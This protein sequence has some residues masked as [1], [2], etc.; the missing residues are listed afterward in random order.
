[1]RRTLLFACS[2]LLI[3]ALAAAQHSSGASSSEAHHSA[4]A[5]TASVNSS[6]A[7]SSSHAESASHLV[8]ENR[9]PAGSHTTGTS[10]SVGSRS[11]SAAGT[12]HGSANPK[13]PK[14]PLSGLPPA[15]F[16]HPTLTPTASSSQPNY[17]YPQSGGSALGGGYLFFSPALY[18]ESD[19]TGAAGGATDETLAND[20]EDAVAGNDA[21][22]NAPECRPP[23]GS[24]SETAEAAGQAP[25][26]AVPEPEA[27]QYVFVRRDGGLLFAIGYSWDRDTLRYITGDGT[28]KAV[29]RDSLDLDATKKFNQQLGL[30]FSIPA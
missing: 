30:I 4:A 22:T 16:H 25:E 2:I 8:A 9:T 12:S 15:A 13:G 11:T 20:S 5:H 1:M 18:F 17:V 23:L 14:S 19:S 26:A 21:G 10:S 28:K 24:H 29:S 6:Q 3:P 27:P 7:V